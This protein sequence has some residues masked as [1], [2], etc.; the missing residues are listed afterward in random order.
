VVRVLT[1]SYSIS[2]FWLL[3]SFFQIKSLQVN[4]EKQEKLLFDIFT[5]F[6]WLCVIILFKSFV[7]NKIEIEISLHCINKNDNDYI[8]CGTTEQLV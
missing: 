7:E 1:I 4:K 8:I 6:P 5:L 2:I 3:T